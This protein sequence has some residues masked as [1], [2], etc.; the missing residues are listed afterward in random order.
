MTDIPKGREIKGAITKEMDRRFL[1]SVDLAGQGTVVLTIDRVEKHELLKYKNGQKKENAI[2]CH[3]EEMDRPL[4]LNATNIK[5]I[6]TMTGT[7]KVSEWVGVK[8]GLLAV[9]GVYFGKKGLAVR[10]DHEY[11]ESK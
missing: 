9:E 3:F 8:I 10:V 11:K 4:E 5:S 2:L 7:N 6:I 1:S